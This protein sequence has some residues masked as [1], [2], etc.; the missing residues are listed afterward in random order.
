MLHQRPQAVAVG[1]DE[2]DVPGGEVGDD[3][4]EEPGHDPLD[5]V[6]QALG[7]RLRC[8]KDVVVVSIINRA[9]GHRETHL[10]GERLDQSP[11]AD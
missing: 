4:V 10:R 5:D 7:G 11:D 8:L 1:G 6:L 9:A 2:D 3:P